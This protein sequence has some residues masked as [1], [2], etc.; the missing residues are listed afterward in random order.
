MEPKKL[1]LP[2]VAVA[3]LFV[4][5]GCTRVTFEKTLDDP[6]VD[7][8]RLEAE[9]EKL[10]KLNKT[11]GH[12][13]FDPDLYPA[14]LGIDVRNGKTLIKKFV[15]EDGCPGSGTV[16]LVYHDVSTEYDCVN[17]RGAPI[18]S[19]GTEPDELIGCEPVVDWHSV[20]SAGGS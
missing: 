10:R 6:V 20:A 3:L 5:S 13:D 1:L 4:L 12:K 15:C 17:A 18:V 16:Y 2:L 11:L 14:F 7:E 9:F 19:Q 8:E